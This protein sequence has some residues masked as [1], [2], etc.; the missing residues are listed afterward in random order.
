MA[1]ICSGIVCAALSTLRPLFGKWMPRMFGSA[2]QVSS[3][4]HMRSSRKTPDIESSGLRSHGTRRGTKQFSRIGGEADEELM[5]SPAEHE[6]GGS[7][8][9]ALSES[10]IE[11]QERS[12]PNP[13]PNGNRDDKN[14]EASDDNGPSGNSLP[15]PEPVYAGLGSPRRS[16]DIVGGDGP[17]ITRAQEHENSVIRVKHEFEV[18]HDE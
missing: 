11:L 12:K 16:V 5:C 15:Y 7:A 9:L 17:Q 1:E 8:F 3:S 10:S 6:A 18:R 2:Q 4:Y 14:N 13:D